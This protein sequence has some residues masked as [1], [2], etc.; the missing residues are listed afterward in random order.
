MCIR[1]TERYA[2][3]RCIYYQH[4]VQPCRNPYGRGH[5]IEERTMWVGYACAAHSRR[6]MGYSPVSYIERSLAGSSTHVYMNTSP[7]T[8]GN[9]LSPT[10]SLRHPLPR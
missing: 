6:R 3:C 1:I 4:A 7:Y 8:L 10:T 2:H 5:R 9:A